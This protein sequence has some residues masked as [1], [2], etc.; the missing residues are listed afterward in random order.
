MP[1]VPGNTIP[2]AGGYGSY[3]GNLYRDRYDWII[4]PGGELRHVAFS[5]GV[6][7]VARNPYVSAGLGVL[8]GLSHLFEVTTGNMYEIDYI[9]DS[10]G[11]GG[12]GQS[13]TSTNSPP[14]VEEVGALLMEISKTGRGYGFDITKSRKSNGK[15]RRCP[16]GMRWSRRLR[17]CVDRKMFPPGF[18]TIP[19]IDR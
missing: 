13:L 6:G 5:A 14:S 18:T 7:L 17:R 4:M 3:P 10:P 8:H 2:G 19:Y 15:R 16:R 1:Q 12:P 11:G 9:D